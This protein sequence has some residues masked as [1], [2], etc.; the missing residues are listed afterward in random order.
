MPP[1]LSDRMEAVEARISAVE[2]SVRHEL[3]EFRE[4]MMSEFTR[5]LEQRPIGTGEQYAH[6]EDS[7]TEY[8]MAVKK[9]ELPSFDGDDPVA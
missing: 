6:S 2:E 9:V 1:K 5:L 8:K 3:R 7:V 4:I